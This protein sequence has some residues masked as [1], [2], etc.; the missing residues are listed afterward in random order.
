MNQRWNVYGSPKLPREVYEKEHAWMWKRRKHLLSSTFVSAETIGSCH[1]P[2]VG[3]AFGGGGIRSAAF[4]TG[5]LKALCHFRNIHFSQRNDSKEWLKF[6]DFLSTVSGGGYTGSAYITYALAE[7]S[8]QRELREASA[9][10]KRRRKSAG[11]GPTP[12]KY[13]SYRLRGEDFRSAMK[14]ALT[15]DVSPA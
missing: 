13:D 8:F 14:P 3:L 6:V 4:Q 5:V 2:K 15:P 11:V 12:R 9:E 10:E 1:L 7:E